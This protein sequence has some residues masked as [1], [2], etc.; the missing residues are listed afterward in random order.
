MRTNLFLFFIM[1]NPTNPSQPKQIRD[2]RM[3]GFQ[4]RTAV[5]VLH[6]LLEDKIQSLEPEEV[7]L[8]RAAGRVLAKSVVSTVPVPHFARAAMDGYALKGAETS[9]A[10]AQ[11][12]MVFSILG[13]SFPARPFSGEVTSGTAVRIMTGA[14]VP[15]GADAVL[16]AEAAEESRSESNA[17]NVVLQVREPVPVGKNVGQIGEDIAEGS[18]ILS[19]GRI[20]R[21]Q[22]CGVLASIGE[23]T[24][25]VIRR[26]T[27]AVLV[28][29][30]ELLPCGSKPEGFRIVD[31]NS[32]ILDALVQR[33]TGLSPRIQMVPDRYE[34]LRQAL[35]TAQEDVVMI[36]G[37]SSVGVEDH[38]PAIVT[39]LGELPVHGLALRPAGPTGV[40][41]IG[42]QVVFL[43][44]GN[45]VSCLCA[46]DLFAGISLRRLGGFRGTLPYRWKS[47]P[48]A[49][50]LLSV[51]GRMD[52]VRVKVAEGKVEPLATS[53]ASIL[54]STTRADGFVLVPG[55]VEGY[56]AGEEV[57]VYFYDP[58]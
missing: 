45:P 25:Q 2:I 3:R 28:T 6:E 38:A 54:S 48:L 29:G 18:T 24:V 43:L 47:L 23:P 13:Q 50:E 41:F 15:Q 11:N 17:E 35:E 58:I 36:S 34:N 21:P 30:N 7:S 37:G 57:G 39:E 32:V 26:P 20:L 27:A 55:E 10:S 9:K 51:A 40:G 42:K 14:P 31:S 52:Y 56:G 33:D 1:S 46:Y 53:G 5:P 12:P 4:Q 22:D 8:R 49:Q 16:K 19:K 44:P